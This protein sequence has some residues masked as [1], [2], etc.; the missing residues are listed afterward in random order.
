MCRTEFANVLTPSGGIPNL[1]IGLGLNFATPGFGLPTAVIDRI[2]LDLHI[3]SNAGPV[4][5]PIFGFG[6]SPG[7]SNAT[8][9]PSSGFYNVGGGGGSGFWNSGTGMSGLLNVFSN[10]ALGSSSGFYNFGTQL[11]GILNRGAGVSGLL[12]TG[13]LGD[14][15]AAVV[16]GFMNVGQQLSGL[17]YTGIGP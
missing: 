14:V 16:S 8:T 10:A 3:N 12:N 11:S 13:A 6:G 9:S 1:P 2:A 7:F 15:T 17:L 5:V 4:Q